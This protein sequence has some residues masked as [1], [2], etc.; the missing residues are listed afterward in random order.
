[1]PH[2]ILGWPRDLDLTWPEVNFW[3]WP[4]EV[5]RYIFRTI[6]TRVTQWC[7]R[8]VSIF[9]SLKVIREK[10]LSPKTCWPLVTLTLTWA[11]KW[12][13]YPWSKSLQGIERRLPCLFSSLGFRD[14]RVG[15][16]WWNHPP[17]P[18]RRGVWIWPTDE[19]R[20]IRFVG[21]DALRQSWKVH[22]NHSTS[23][24]I[25]TFLGARVAWPGLLTWSEMTWGLLF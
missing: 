24:A 17:P 18:T 16:G 14:R 13:K 10:W 6:S 19:F 15:G 2:D 11:K 12:P 3:P 25:W 9:I 23:D 8:R 4:C 22:I 5:K 1:M 7:Y 20:D 21:T